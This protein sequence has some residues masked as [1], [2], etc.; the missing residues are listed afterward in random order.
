MS[1]GHEEEGVELAGLVLAARAGRTEAFSELVERCIG[2]VHAI[3]FARVWNRETAEDIAQEAFLRAFLHMDKLSEPR[4][5]VTWLVCIT[6]NLTADWNRSEMRASS[7]VSFVPGEEPENVTVADQTPDPRQRAEAGQMREALLEAVKRLPPDLREVIIL[8]YMEDLS[9][10]HIAQA[11]GVNAST[12]GRRMDRALAMLR[13][14]MMDALKPSLSP[15]RIPGSRIAA[16]SGAAIAIALLDAP[17]RVAIA[18]QVPLP[19]L[20]SAAD[21]TPHTFSESSLSVGT[22]GRFMVRVVATIVALVVAVPAVIHYTGS[23]H[24][25]VVGAAS[26]AT[27]TRRV[28]A[29]VSEASPRSKSNPIDRVERKSVTSRKASETTPSAGTVTAFVGST[30]RV[31]PINTEEPGVCFW[32][33]PVGEERQRKADAMPPI[34]PREGDPARFLHALVFVSTDTSGPSTDNLV[35]K[36]IALPKFTPPVMTRAERISAHQSKIDEIIAQDRAARMRGTLPSSTPRPSPR[37]RPNSASI[38]YQRLADLGVYENS[39]QAEDE[40]EIIWFYDQVG[41]DRDKT[42]QL[43]N[44][45]AKWMTVHRALSNAQT[46]STD[47]L[48]WLALDY[49]ELVTT[50]QRALIRKLT[51]GGT[52]EA[53]FPACSVMDFDRILAPAFLS[54]GVSPDNVAKLREINSELGTVDTEFIENENHGLARIVKRNR[55]YMRQAELTTED[56]KLMTLKHLQDR[57]V[58]IQ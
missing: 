57:G 45:S 43:M 58:P 27:R 5:F 9:K 21:S 47:E 7:L 41:I 44:L 50:G 29:A 54:A 23:R 33:W 11:L 48:L 24:R 13:V 12:I 42:E 18:G 38:D 2:R 51:S 14:E 32:R 19:L 30:G 52:L 53:R 16:I 55:L 8:H 31:W 39:L 40:K 49:R 15:V 56:Q 28:A 20:P 35:R 37:P 25:A 4:H 36:Q 17:A 3:A 46:T 1:S 26:G 34:V 10:I 6:R 22:G